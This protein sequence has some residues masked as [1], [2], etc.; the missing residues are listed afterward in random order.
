MCAVILGF[1][2]LGFIAADIMR[3]EVERQDVALKA[4]VRTMRALQSKT[5]AVAELCADPETKK[6][7]AD[8]AEKFRYSDPVSSE[9]TGAL[10]TDLAAAVDELQ[11]A[12]ADGDL[13]SAKA[14]CG[15]IEAALNER[16]RIC[17]L[18]K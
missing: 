18:N 4:D 9:A 11:A 6:A 12:A 16:N 17:R 1:S 15:K 13:A 7:L 10:E 14:L 2:A 8:L 5:A 3:D